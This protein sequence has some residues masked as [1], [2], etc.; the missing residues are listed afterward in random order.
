VNVAGFGSDKTITTLSGGTFSTTNLKY[1]RVS[2]L[3]DEN[4]VRLTFLSGSENKFDIKLDPLRTMMFT[5]SKISGSATGASFNDFSDFT[6][7]KAISDSDSV[8][9]ELFVASG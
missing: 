9:V 6:D 4:Y 5:N 8:D 3:D 2:N 1:F 7:L